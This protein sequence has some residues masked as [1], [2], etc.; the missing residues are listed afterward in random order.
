VKAM[1]KN[2]DNINSKKKKFYK[3]LRN[4][5]LGT[6]YSSYLDDIAQKTE[7]YVFSGVIRDFFIHKQ[8]KRDL[9]IVVIDYPED[10]LRDFES[11]T[12]FIS[13]TVNKFG[14]IKLIMED[15]TIDIWRLRDTWGI[16]KKKL[17]E[18][19]ANSLSETVFF[20]FSSIV[21]DYNNIEF[22]NYERFARFLKDKTMDVVFSRNV[23]DVCCIV[24]TLHYKKDYDFGISDKLAR[25]LRD[26]Y[27]P[28][29]DFEGVQLRR[30]G[31]VEFTP[32][33]IKKLILKEL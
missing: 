6:E 19:N 9:D 17:D 27:N 14:G 8:G 1:K 18:T 33:K 15:L 21:F 30:F 31:E 25:W 26:K 29:M 3:Y 2:S 23:D 5:I 32:E 7:V 22:L 28:K 20:N 10:F 13:E 24:S 16:K 4:R 11:D 12:R